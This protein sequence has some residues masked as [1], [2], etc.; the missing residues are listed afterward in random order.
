MTRGSSYP[1]SVRVL[2]GASLE[3]IAEVERQARSLFPDAAVFQM[4]T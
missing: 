2:T 4:P 3:K 1:E